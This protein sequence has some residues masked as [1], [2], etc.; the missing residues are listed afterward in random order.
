[1]LWF[2]YLGDTFP[3]KNGFELYF[4]FFSVWLNCIMSRHLCFAHSYDS[5]AKTLIY[6]AKNIR[7]LNPIGTSKS[8]IK[9]KYTW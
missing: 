4:F 8:V 2:L 9:K 6:C 5:F 3:A 1:M 7:D